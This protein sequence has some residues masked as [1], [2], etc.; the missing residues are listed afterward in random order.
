RRLRASP[1]RGDASED[2]PR[3]ARPKPARRSASTLDRLLRN[4]E[5]DVAALTAERD[6]LAESLA[7]AGSDHEA[8]SRTATGLAEV[9]ARLDA[10]EERWLALAEE[11]DS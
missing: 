10:A 7:A 11:A 2:E 6:G 9:Q 3:P 1:S 8:L 4:A 5:R